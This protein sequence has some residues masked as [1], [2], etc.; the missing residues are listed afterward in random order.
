M[1]TKTPN[2]LYEYYG[3]LEKLPTHA[4]FSSGEQLE[5]YQ[6]QRAALFQNHL[7]IPLRVFQNA[8]LVE[9]GPD[10]GENSLV[11]GLWGSSLTLV[12]PNS[13]AHPEIQRYF[14]RFDLAGRLDR[15]VQT[16]L[17][18][19]TSS[20]KYDIIDAEG[21][22]YT[23]QHNK[24]WANLFSN[25]LTDNGLAIISYYES[26]G[27]LFELFFKL[28]HSRAMSFFDGQD[29]EAVAAKVFASKWDSIEHTRTFSSWVMDVLENPFVRLRY[30]LDAADL[31]SSMQ[32]SGLS[33]YSSWPS[34]RDSASIYWHKRPPC[35]QLTR[36]RTEMFLARSCLSF[37]FGRKLLIC[38]G[39][40]R[41]VTQ[42][43]NDL[44]KLIAIVDRT[45]DESSSALLQEA[46]L[47]MENLRR[48]LDSAN[49]L[50]D[51][52]DATIEA[53]QYLDVL[54]EIT[55]LLISNDLPRVCE[56]CNTNEHFLAAWG[57]PCHYAVF[58][59]RTPQQ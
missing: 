48:V 29:S 6:Q 39:S 11:F 58:Q 2:S 26:S 35:E 20:S 54:A 36:S 46:L 23:I 50:A 12:E 14:E 51:S 31:C 1:K 43:S 37:A 7:S 10:S 21:F 32:Q 42:I 9:F 55:G 4:A 47:L 53:I 18:H 41:V 52:A 28:I 16:D 34:Y 57:Q 15:L 40:E 5:A 24:I 38:E 30:F 56:I 59:K 17:Q 25:I 8:H 44:H 22:I 13:Q 27:S 33:L 3:A 45:I 49:L 19:F